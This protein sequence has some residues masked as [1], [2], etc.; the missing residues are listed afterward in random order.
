MQWYESNMCSFAEVLSKTAK[1]DKKPYLYHT[2]IDMVWAKMSRASLKHHRGAGGEGVIII[3]FPPNE[4]YDHCN[5]PHHYY[6][7]QNQ[8]CQPCKQ[9]WGWPQG[10]PFTKHKIYKGHSHHNPPDHYDDDHHP[11]GNHHH[12]DHH[13]ECK[14][15]LTLLRRHQCS[16]IFQCS[17]SHNLKPILST[18]SIMVVIVLKIFKKIYRTEMCDI[19]F[20]SKSSSTLGWKE[21]AVASPN[22]ILAT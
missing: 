20:P 8:A 3:I 4:L 7:D 1:N 5:P 13:I 2:G 12:D 14:R 17:T 18:N 10:P 19:F 6:D 16:T 22:L 9:S 15:S 21:K 11:K